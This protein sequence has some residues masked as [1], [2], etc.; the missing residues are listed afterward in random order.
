MDGLYAG[1]LAQKNIVDLILSYCYHYLLLQ[2]AIGLLAGHR[3]GYKTNIL[4][5]KNVPMKVCCGQIQ[6]WLAQHI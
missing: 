1:D 4:E 6:H 2:K 3:P 5:N